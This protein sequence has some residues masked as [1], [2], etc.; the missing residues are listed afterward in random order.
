M[1]Y[2]GTDHDYCFMLLEAAQSKN[3]V[4]PLLPLLL[5]KRG[6][7]PITLCPLLPLQSKNVVCPLLPLATRHSMT[8]AP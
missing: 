6:L 7:S 1:K 5:K 3:V 2:L 4:C 8:G